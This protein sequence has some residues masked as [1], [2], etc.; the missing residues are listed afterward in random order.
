MVIAMLLPLTSEDLDAILSW[1]N[2][3]DVRR[4]MFSSHVISVSEHRAW[5]EAL[6][7]DPSRQV[8]VYLLGNK[9]VG[10]VQFTEIN[11]NSGTAFWGF[12]LRPSTPVDASLRIELAAATHAFENMKLHKLSCEVIEFNKKVLNMHKMR[13]QNRG[14]ISRSSLGRRA[15]PF[16]FSSRNVT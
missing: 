15:I 16:C 6:R 3:P 1:R 10:V 14:R 5:F 2:Q 11:Q 4:C 12:Y 7:E 8:F 13:I 9:K